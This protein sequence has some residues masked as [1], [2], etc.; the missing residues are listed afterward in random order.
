MNAYT[1]TQQPQNK[2]KA[3][4]ELTRNASICQ[5]R[6]ILLFVKM[7][8]NKTLINYFSSTFFSERSHFFEES[9]GLV[10]TTVTSTDWSSEMQS[11]Y[12]G[13]MFSHFYH[14]SW[15]YLVYLGLY[16]RLTFLILYLFPC[17]VILFIKQGCTYKVFKC[18]FIIIINH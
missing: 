3:W 8:Y 11:L 17:N 14:Q 5:L 2:H 12:Q 7:L 16:L 4:L 10:N 9:I 1:F 13:W 15:S 6:C 18:I